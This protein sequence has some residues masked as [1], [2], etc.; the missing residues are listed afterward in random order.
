MVECTLARLGPPKVVRPGLR[1]IYLGTDEVALTRWAAACGRPLPEAATRYAETCKALRQPFVEWIDQL[2]RRYGESFDW[3]LQPFSER[4]SML[5]PL[6]ANVTYVSLAIDLI[7]AGQLDMV[8]AEDASVI[9]ALRRNREK[10]VTA[11]S[12]ATRRQSG[13][14]SHLRAAIA[15]TGLCVW[16]ALAAR[17]TKPRRSRLKI[18]SRSVLWRTYLPE[19][20]DPASAG[21]T[22]PYVP[23]LLEWLSAQGIAVW[24]VAV[25]VPSRG[26][27][28]RWLKQYRTAERA[29]VPEDF[30]EWSDYV[31]AFS[32]GWY[33][34]IHPDST[35]FFQ[36]L[37]VSPLA[38]AERCRQ[39]GTNSARRAR[40]LSRVP[41]RLAQYGLDPTAIL[42]WWEHQALDKAFIQGCRAA[43]PRKRILAIS[44]N[45]LPLNQLNLFPTPLECEVGV[46]PDVIWCGGPAAAELLRSGSNGSAGAVT[47]AAARYQYLWNVQ[48]RA[49]SAIRDVLVCLPVAAQ[50]ATGLLAA[51]RQAALARPDIRWIVKQHPALVESFEPTSTNIA[52]T[53]AP[54]ATLLPLVD[55]VLTT[56]SGTAL[57]ALAAGLRVLIWAGQMAVPF[58]PAG[59]E[60]ST[61]ARLCFTLDD[62]IGALDEPAPPLPA[63]EALALRA[64]WFQSVT[65]SSFE[66][67]WR[68]ATQSDSCEARESVHVS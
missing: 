24:T 46:V 17:L 54:L 66:V 45:G 20:R 10:A 67:L 47:G 9:E 5:S 57:E 28:L 43:Y 32:C 25:R 39:A 41:V 8:V 4:N 68:Q 15:F 27:G 1:W 33:G 13:T 53:T 64:D 60:R 42:T 30:L 44:N 48:V 21:R 49:S 19:S 26:Y 59:V 14:L 56:A 29:L 38:E 62:L 35:H 40:L 34:R 52:L 51:V 63:A 31:D 37:D 50:P 6:F 3:W 36:G 18:E 23:G 22:D 11:D 55:G 16:N 12:G 7:D 65:S 58:T 2:G 61:Y